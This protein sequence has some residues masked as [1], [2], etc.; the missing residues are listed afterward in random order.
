MSSEERWRGEKSRRGCHRRLEGWAPPGSAS[1]HP[2]ETSRLLCPST[3][4]LNKRVRQRNVPGKKGE[5]LGR[6]ALLQPWC[7]PRRIGGAGGEER[8][9]SGGGTK[10]LEDIQAL[11]PWD[12]ARLRA[13][14]PENYQSTS[15]TP[16]LGPQRHGNATKS[17]SAS[18]GH[19]AELHVSTPKTPAV[20][21]A[22]GRKRATD[23][24]RHKDPSGVHSCLRTQ[25]GEVSVL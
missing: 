13:C 24:C 14:K 2:P 7:G 6:A 3:C 18:P 11:A 20:R 9:C 19:L 22:A 21:K 16:W 10:F 25:S 8:N 1:A 23:D 4:S 15:F 12:E 17:P 5:E